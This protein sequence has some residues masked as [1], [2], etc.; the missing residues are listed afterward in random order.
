MTTHTM[1]IQPIAISII[2]ITPFFPAKFVTLH[3]SSLYLRNHAAVNKSSLK[4]N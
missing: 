2:L 4:K 1:V 3:I